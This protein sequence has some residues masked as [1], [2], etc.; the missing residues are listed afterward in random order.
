MMETCGVRNE[1][2]KSVERKTRTQSTKKIVLR[3]RAR[4]T[5]AVAN[6]DIGIT[7]VTGISPYSSTPKTLAVCIQQRMST[8]FFVSLKKA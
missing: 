1:I 7:L 6:T 2:N 8:K 5:V 4:S 3:T